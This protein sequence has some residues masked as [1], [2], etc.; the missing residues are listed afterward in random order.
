MVPKIGSVKGDVQ[1]FW[2]RMSKINFS[3]SDLKMTQQNINIFLGS[4]LA[5]FSHGATLCVEFIIN[6]KC[7]TFFNKQFSFQCLLE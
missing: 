7:G 5:G 6:K 1:G 4:C 2:S 3:E